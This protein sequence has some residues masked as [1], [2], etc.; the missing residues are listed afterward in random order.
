MSA[1]T[2]RR[3]AIAGAVLLILCATI[4]VLSQMPPTKLWRGVANWGA[5]LERE[6][7]D[8]LHVFRSPSGSQ[9]ML[10]ID[11]DKFGSEI[12]I[13]DLESKD[14]LFSGGGNCFFAFGQ[15]FVRT[16]IPEGKI[17]GV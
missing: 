5:G 11:R 9:V 10:R 16:D 15:A 14:V 12:Y 17:C 7:V 4:A 1:V 3:A 6:P 8:R 2:K 13:I